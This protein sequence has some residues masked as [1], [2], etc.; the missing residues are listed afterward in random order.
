MYQVAFSPE[1]K[2]LVTNAED[3]TVRVWEVTS[4]QEVRRMAHEGGV[5][6]FTLS[7]DGKLL[8]T[9]GEDHMA[10]LWEVASGREIR[11]MADEEAVFAVGFSPDSKWLATAN[12][13]GTVRVWEIASGR[14]VAHAPRKTLSGPRSLAQ[15]GSIWSQAR[16]GGTIRFGCGKWLVAGKSRAWSTMELN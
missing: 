12:R 15:M 14:Q 11:R 16:E 5:R 4:G 1:S 9:A 13:N 3:S 7:P 6:A 10:R 2:Y 8:A